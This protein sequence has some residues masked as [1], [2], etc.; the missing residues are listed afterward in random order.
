[1]CPFYFGKIIPLIFTISWK[2]F[3]K[4]FPTLHIRLTVRYY[5]IYPTRLVYI[6]YTYIYLYTL[7][8]EFGF[9]LLYM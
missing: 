9:K 4:S 3:Q 6:I 7:L 5:D 8:Y 1:M 2:I